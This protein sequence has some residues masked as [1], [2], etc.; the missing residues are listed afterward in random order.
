[1]SVYI[2]SYIDMYEEDQRENHLSLSSSTYV[3]IVT[4]HFD[5][6]FNCL[7]LN[8]HIYANYEMYIIKHIY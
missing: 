1:M 8:V 3:T 4:L 6:N 5:S 7:I 2:Y